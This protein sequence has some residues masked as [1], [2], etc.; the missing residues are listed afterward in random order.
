[1]SQ[2]VVP[3]ILSGGT[4]TRL[5]PLSRKQHPKPFIRLLG[6]HTLLQ[7]TAQRLRAL[8]EALPPIV[9]CGEA[10]RF[11]VAEQLRDAGVPPQTIILEP[12]V[13]N[14]AP[15]IAAAAFEAIARSG[16]GG[17][18][19][20]LVLPADHAIRDEARFADA[21]RIAVGE[22][23]SG[24]LVAF[25]VVPTHAETGYGYIT[26]G[27]PAEPEGG[28]RP[29]ERFI[30]KPDADTALACMAAGNCYWNSGMF[31]FGARQFLHDLDSH[32]TEIRRA[33]QAAHENA[34]AEPGFRI[35]DAEAFARSPARSVDRAVMERAANAAVVPFDAGWSDI[36]SWANL[37]ALSEPDDAGNVIR[38]DA[39]LRNTENS[40]ILGEDRMVA[41]VGVKDIVI[42]DTPDAVLVLD[43]SSA[44]DVKALVAE[45]ERAGRDGREG[46]RR[47]HRPWG[48]YQSVHDGDGFKVKHIVV[49]PGRRL[50]LQAHRCRAEHWVVIRGVAR[51]TR[52]GEVFAL[53]EDE[54]VHIPAGVRHRLENPGSAPLELIEVQMG[55]YL[56]EDDIVRFEDDYG[57]AGAGDG[58]P[59]PA[60]SRPSGTRGT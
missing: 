49:R 20:L 22:A 35:L 5:W 9:V 44:Q 38:G 24:R 12:A 33:V 3:V 2:L 56:G 48:S 14:T 42:V 50:S 8:E 16:R 47:V 1:M 7:A 43:K 18:P 45:L 40:F 23:A 29:V 31:V 28:A 51:V 55:R 41:A 57:R 36:G 37:A 19:I 30:E 32:A 58:S 27:P 21:V 54:S 46:L 60:R 26:A 13:R 59:S 17:D 53:A 11:T 4:G 6:D 25:G 39:V 15:A 10:H 34:A 52:D